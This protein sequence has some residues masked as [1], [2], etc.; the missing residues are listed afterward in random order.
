MTESKGLVIAIVGPTSPIG[1]AIKEELPSAGLSIREVNLLD[2]IDLVGTLTE[3]D[4]GAELVTRLT[5]ETV[6]SSDVVFFCDSPSI[7]AECIGSL[8]EQEAERPIVVDLSG[9][10]SF[11]RSIPKMTSRLPR[12]R[13]HSNLMAL[14]D[15]LAVGLARVLD[16]CS[17]IEDIECAAA[18]CL[19]PVSELG[20]EGSDALR[21]QA[22]ELLNFAAVPEDLFGGQLIFNLHPGF[23]PAGED[24]GRSQ[25][26]EMISAQ[27]SA[28]LERDNL[29]IL[30]SAVRVPIFFSTAISLFIKFRQDVAEAR[31]R[32][33]IEADSG[34]ELSN[35][36][37]ASRK[38][39]TPLDS[40]KSRFYQVGRIIQLPGD[41]SA[42]ML[43]ISYDNILLGG[44][45]D[46]IELAKQALSSF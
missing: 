26:E 1:K 33:A 28:L 22:T 35:Y 20:N 30:L 40:S 45:L 37:S 6:N 24:A 16:L 38:I 11:D 43:W 42:F 41:K 2:E 36:M 27:I 29:P 25:F 46:A 9:S 21:D 10:S 39:P 7:A 23:G 34:F 14:P 3:Y 8:V 18:T 12:S 13:V 31:L 4:G 19:L 44:V 32:E 17:D 5:M 15:S